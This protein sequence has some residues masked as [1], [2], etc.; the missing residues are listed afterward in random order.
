MNLNNLHML[1]MGF[2]G[3]HYLLEHMPSQWLKLH[4]AIPYNPKGAC[5]VMGSSVWFASAIN[6]YQLRLLYMP[7]IVRSS[8]RFIDSKIRFNP[9][10]CMIRLGP[11]FA[12]IE[13]FVWLTPSP[14]KPKA[15][16]GHKR[17]LHNYCSAIWSCALHCD[18][19]FDS[20]QGRV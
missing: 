8:R 14:K 10:S 9:L 15:E 18:S 7:N 11:V 5:G 16:T 19:L 12:P 13:S 3:R 2:V 6:R 17:P 1:H 20:H 4:Q